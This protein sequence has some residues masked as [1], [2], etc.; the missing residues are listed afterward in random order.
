MT[1]VSALA[2]T[3]FL[4]GYQAPF[5]LH[6]L[7]DGR[8]SA[9]WL[10]LLW[11]T[12]KLWVF[13]WF[14]VW[15]RGTLPRTRYD[16][17][18]KFGWKVLIPVALAWVVMV[19]VVQGIRQF[20]GMDLTTMLLWIAGVFIAIMAVLLLWPARREPAEPAAPEPTEFDAFAGGFPVPP[21][22]GQQLPPSP[23]RRRREAAMAMNAQEA[24][25]E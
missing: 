6:Y 12:A 15:L 24:T 3:M 9:G 11:F 25:D 20:S 18:M 21:M 1:T 16:Q 7:M 19:A 14:F 10:G 2:T 4:G 13:M 8:L 22:P 23:R 17:F 5:G